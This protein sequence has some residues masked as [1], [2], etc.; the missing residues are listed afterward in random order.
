MTVINGHQKIDWLLNQYSGYVLQPVKTFVLI[1]LLMSCLSVSFLKFIVNPIQHFP[2]CNIHHHMQYNVIFDIFMTAT[3][4]KA[5]N[6]SKSESMSY[7]FQN[8]FDSKM[9]TRRLA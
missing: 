9:L 4:K 5:L 1:L 8:Q 7:P 6:I 3:L 2:A